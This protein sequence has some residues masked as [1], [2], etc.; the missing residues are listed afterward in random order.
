MYPFLEIFFFSLPPP[1]P[2]AIKTK[3]K[4]TKVGRSRPARRKKVCII[5]NHKTKVVSVSVVCVY[6]QKGMP[7]RQASMVNLAPT[8]QRQRR[9]ARSTSRVCSAAKRKAAIGGPLGLPQR[10]DLTKMRTQPHFSL[11]PAACRPPYPGP[12]SR[13]NRCVVMANIS[14][15]EADRHIVSLSALATQRALFRTSTGPGNYP[16]RIATRVR[17]PSRHVLSAKASPGGASRQV[18]P[19]EPRESRGNK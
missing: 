18:Q 17:S 3:H 7:V 14:F 2:Y 1:P 13:L 11:L 12:G 4:K 15:L 9:A 19:S 5:K 10:C 6:P 16:H 8:P